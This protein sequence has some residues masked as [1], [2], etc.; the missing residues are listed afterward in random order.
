MEKTIS[1]TKA[2]DELRTIVDEVQF[3]GDK[4]VVHR[5][6]K[7]AVAIVPI[8]IYDNWKNQRSRLIEIMEEVHA[9]NPDVD[10]DEVMRDV[11]EAQQAV[12]VQ[13]AELEKCAVA[14]KAQYIITG[15]NYLLDIGDY[16]GIKIITPAVFIALLSS[17]IL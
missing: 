16:E 8:H 6:G 10:P 13:Q 9:A 3:H 2:R 17:E 15:D 14:G 11:L 1:V 4:Y 7:P 5:H 12:R